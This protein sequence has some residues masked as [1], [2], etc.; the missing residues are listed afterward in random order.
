MPFSAVEALQVFGMGRQMALEDRERVRRERARE[1]VMSRAQAGDYG[2][3][4][5]AAIAEGQFDWASSLGRLDDTQRE[6]ALQE[7]QIGGEAARALRAVPAEQ[8]PGALQGLMPALR[9]GGF[10][11]EEIAAYSAD[12][13]DG[14][15]D[16]LIGN[17]DAIARVIK[18]QQAVQPTALERNYSFFQQQDP[19]LADT[20]L[21]SQAEGPPV[22]FDVNGD[23]YPDLVPR[24]YIQRGG[25]AVQTATNPQ[26]GEKIQL[27]PETGQWEPVG[28]PASAPG[29]FP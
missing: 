13:S 22:T 15:L 24:S 18:P 23:G 21:Q 20:Y 9:A 29:G 11:D 3:A 27:N 12:L 19:A 26:T 5:Q 28:G 17:A 25:A 14:V 16:G 7:A 6:R 1:N 10:S 8:R 2:G 4:Q